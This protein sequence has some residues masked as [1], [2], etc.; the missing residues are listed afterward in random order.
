MHRVPVTSSN[1][2]SIGF[3]PSSNVLEVAFTHGGVYQY[4]GVPALVHAGLMDT[5][6]AGQSV[7]RYFD[8]HVKKAGY[9]YVVL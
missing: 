3:D 5:D 7:G 8:V 4:F 9:T 2:E 1:I 6:R